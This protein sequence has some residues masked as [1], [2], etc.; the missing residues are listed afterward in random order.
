VE[1]WGNLNEPEVDEWRRVN[2][3][4]GRRHFEIA[5]RRQLLMGNSSRA[6]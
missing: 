3:I 1:G 2:E 5:G 6:M 4:A